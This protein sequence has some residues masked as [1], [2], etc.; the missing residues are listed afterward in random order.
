MGLYH[1]GGVIPTQVFLS[2]REDATQAFWWRTYSPPI[3]LLDHKNEELITR[4]L[5]GMKPESM[6]AVLQNATSSQCS[7][8]GPENSEE[9]GVYLIAP[10]SST[11][12]DKYTNPTKEDSKLHPLYFEQVWQYRR[13]LN[14]DDL[15]F[16]EDGVWNTLRRVVGR[17][18]LVV[19]KIGRN[20]AKV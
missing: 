16:A 17:R 12:L 14:L 18:G 19:W 11:W 9:D 10:K 6:L 2:T 15:D 4:D 8:R 3:W 13:H 5:M 1:Q 7:R 20:C